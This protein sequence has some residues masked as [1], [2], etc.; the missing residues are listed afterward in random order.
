MMASYREPNCKAKKHDYKRDTATQRKIQ[1]TKSKET[2]GTATRTR[3][4]CRRRIE[5]SAT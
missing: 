5:D 2:L 1:G 3:E 4:D